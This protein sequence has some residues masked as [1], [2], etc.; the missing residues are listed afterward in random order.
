MRGTA[1]PPKHKYG[2]GPKREP[3]GPLPDPFASVGV[4][5]AAKPKSA[6]PVHAGL[7]FLAGLGAAC[8]ARPSTRDVRFDQRGVFRVPLPTRS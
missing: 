8:N 7:A 1:R 6:N 3:C 4:F 5:N 2:A